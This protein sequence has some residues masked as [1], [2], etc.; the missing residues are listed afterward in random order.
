[1]SDGTSIAP[2]SAA[3]VQ[4]LDDAALAER[5]AAVFGKRASDFSRDE[6]KALA[7]LW[8]RREYQRRGWKAP[9]RRMARPSPQPSPQMQ[10]DF[11]APA[12]GDAA[13]DAPLSPPQRKEA[14]HAEKFR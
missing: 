12:R 7:A 8:T 11:T 9:K 5:V 13:S 10:I 6:I 14:D 3:I 4:A 2:T 1:M